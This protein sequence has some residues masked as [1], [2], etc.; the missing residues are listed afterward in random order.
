M[1]TINIK[2]DLLFEAL[3]T[4]Y[5]NYFQ[6]TIANILDTYLVVIL[7]KPMKSLTTYAFHMGWSSMK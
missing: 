6:Y 3:G 1:P 4:S 5:S 7:F 2:K